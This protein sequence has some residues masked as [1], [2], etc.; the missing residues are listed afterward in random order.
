MKKLVADKKVEEMFYRLNQE[1]QEKWCKRKGENI[2][3]ARESAG[4]TRQASLRFQE[5]RTKEE[6]CR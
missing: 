4:L 2:R 6:R 5:E 1:D 3:D